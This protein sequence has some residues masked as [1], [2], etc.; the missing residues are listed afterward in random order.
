MLCLVATETLLRVVSCC[1][2]C[3]WRSKRRVWTSAGV[4]GAVSRRLPV[5]P[6]PCGFSYWA[7]PLCVPVGGGPPASRPRCE[8]SARCVVSKPGQAPP[9]PTGTAADP[10][11]ALHTGGAVSLE[12]GWVRRLEARPGPVPR[13]VPYPQFRM[14]FPDTCSSSLSEK[15]GISTITFQSMKCAWGNCMRICADQASPPLTG[16]AAWSLYSL[17]ASWGFRVLSFWGALVRVVTNVVNPRCFLC[18]FLP[19]CCKRR[20]SI[21]FLAENVGFLGLD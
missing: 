20:Q 14:Q 18:G 7:W 19:R 17:G 1:L 16:T 3:R 11:G 10:S 6:V 5:F 12:C 4:S 2:W 21:G 15:P 9:P 8:P 13:S